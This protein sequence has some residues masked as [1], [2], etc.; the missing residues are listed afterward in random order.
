MNLAE[1]KNLLN[2]PFCSQQPGVKDVK[3]IC[4]SD[5]MSE[6]LLLADRDSV[7]ITNLVNL[8]AIRTAEM[9]ESSCI[10][11]VRGKTPTKDMVSLAEKNGIT[12]LVTEYDMLETCGILYGRGLQHKK[13]AHDNH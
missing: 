2:C 8:Q 11:F 13:V 9:V 3:S 6:V 5:L 10:V 1:L 4:A 7:I 12:L